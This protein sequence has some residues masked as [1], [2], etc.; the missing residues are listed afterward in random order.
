[1]LQGDERVGQ[2]T[3]KKWGAKERCNEAKN[4]AKDFVRRKEDEVKGQ[5]Y[6]VAVPLSCHISSL[7][8]V[9]IHRTQ[10]TR[11]PKCWGD[12]LSLSPLP[13]LLNDGETMWF[14]TLMFDAPSDAGRRADDG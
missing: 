7:D 14:H 6:M 4:K 2:L 5:I 1:M 9:H 13:T 12:H 10:L 8:H 11:N 3:A